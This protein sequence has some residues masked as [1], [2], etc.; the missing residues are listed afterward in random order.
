MK[1]VRKTTQFWFQTKVKRCFSLGNYFAAH[2]VNFL[3]VALFQRLGACG[4]CVERITHE[5]ERVREKQK[6]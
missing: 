3:N 1:F 4:E 5:R 6:E 2:M